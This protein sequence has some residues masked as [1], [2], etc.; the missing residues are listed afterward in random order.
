M[1]K[2][3]GLLGL[4][5]LFSSCIQNYST[6][7]TFEKSLYA[8]S[9]PEAFESV[10]PLEGVF[11]NNDWELF[12]PENE[13][14][15]NVSVPEFK[16]TKSIDLPHR[17]AKPNSPYWYRKTIKVEPG[18]LMLNADDGAQLWVNGERQP[19]L[20]AEIFP[21]NE[22]G[23]VELTIRVLNN[24]MSGGLR[25]A[26][27]VSQSDWNAY[28]EKLQGRYAHWLTSTKIKI[29]DTANVPLIEPVLLTD[30]VWLREADGSF[31]VKWVSEKGGSARLVWGEQTHHLRHEIEVE[32][33]DGNFVVLLPRTS[34]TIYYQVLQDGSASPEYSMKLEPN[35]KKQKFAIWGDSQGGWE[36]FK[37]IIG[38]M[39]MH[40]PA[41]SVGAGDL[42][43]YGSEVSGYLNLMQSLS[44]A[45]FYHYPVVGNHDYDGYYED[46]IPRN[47]HEYSNIPDRPTYFSW[48]EGGAAFIAIDPNA[49]F[50]VSIPVGSEQYNWLMEQFKA[51]FWTS[52]DWRF[53]VL[54]QPPFS[55]GWPGYHGEQ[56]ILELLEPYYKSGDI[57]VMINGHSH[58]YERLIKDYNGKEVAFVVSGGAGGGLEPMGNSDWPVMDLVVNAHHFG[59]FTLKEKELVFE[60]YNLENELIDTFTL[61]KE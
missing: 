4:M 10:K 37:E 13:T 33:E 36:V 15:L 26:K 34:G 12:E 24:A 20:E 40:K 57:D 23:E 47:Y 35:N 49:F 53:V 52:A 8:V 54:H 56:S 31:Y 3:R 46:Y 42:V 44:G 14:G 7:P 55:Q 38:L 21:I 30:P 9:S 6:E 18:V 41:Y 61:S 11:I 28:Q 25:W 39:N 19:N 60:A 48:R 58:D 32:S 1:M 59:L 16:N 22:S 27:W 29:V 50:P 45:E 17:V 5:V 51:D 2:S 43:G